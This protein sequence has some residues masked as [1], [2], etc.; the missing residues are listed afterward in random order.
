MS[1][2]ALGID[3]GRLALLTRVRVP[4]VAET[5]EAMDARTTLA[6]AFACIGRDRLPLV[7]SLAPE[8]RTRP[9]ER[10]HLEGRA[11]RRLDRGAGV[12]LRPRP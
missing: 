7:T 1:S 12:G 4:R 5:L 10:P 3:H 11:A 9:R 8:D 6:T 2:A